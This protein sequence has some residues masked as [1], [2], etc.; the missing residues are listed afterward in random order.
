MKKVCCLTM[1]VCGAAFGLHWRAI[2]RR[3][4]NLWHCGEH[5]RKTGQ[6][7]SL[8][9]DSC[10]WGLTGGHHFR[11]FSGAAVDCSSV[12][13]CSPSRLMLV[14]VEHSVVD[15]LELCIWTCCVLSSWMINR[16]RLQVF[17]V[18]F[19]FAD[20]TGRFRVLLAAGCVNLFASGSIHSKERSRENFFP[21]PK[22]PSFLFFL[23]Y[24]FP[25]GW[26]DSFGKRR[27]SKGH[28][29]ICLLYLTNEH[30]YQC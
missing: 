16:Q 24:F 15:V 5:A 19:Y 26:I 23:F 27:Y 22:H 13:G 9:Q 14:L 6:A 7:V 2:Y 25:F 12:A 10:E 8:E 4:G 18:L 11:G 30:K 21:L 20:Y 3:R 17:K 29:C 28:V 1:L